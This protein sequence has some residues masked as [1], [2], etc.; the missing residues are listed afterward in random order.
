MTTIKNPKLIRTVKIILDLIYGLLIGVCIFLIMW[1][2]I[3]PF[4]AKSGD[5]VI[6]ASVPVAIGSGDEPRFD[7]LLPGAA[8]KGIHSAFVEE[9]Q[10]T[11]RLETTSW[12]F[13]AISNV[14][15]LLT[16][17]GLAWVFYLL[18]LVLLAIQKGETFTPQNAEHIRKIGYLVLL[19]GFLRPAVEYFAAQEVLRQLVVVEPA[20]SL[21]SPFKAEVILG[22]LL[23]LVLA[24]V[25]SYGI[26]L[27]R[28]Q[29]LTI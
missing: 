22:S 24:Q 16:A 15:K 2:A 26:E 14:A 19:I 28:D 6:S 12:S 7:I 8:A 17:G 23:I 4:L 13:I 21:P 5:I 1:M 20:L 29:A 27:E 3:S 11:L 10:G 9:A 25:W 18:R